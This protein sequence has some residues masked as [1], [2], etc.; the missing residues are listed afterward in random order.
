MSE[1][2]ELKPRVEKLE[3]M[4]NQTSKAIIEMEVDFKHLSRSVEKIEQTM[5]K[6]VQLM[7]KQ[8][9]NQ[10]AIK[11]AHHRIDALEANF[12]KC[13]SDKV[14]KVDFDKLD[15][16]IGNLTLKE[17]KGEWLTALGS[18]AVQIVLGIILAGVLALVMTKK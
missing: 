7:A 14:K 5:E 18:K 6:A 17:A 1:D 9:A 11:S 3:D 2:S 16:K 10:S 15:E 13:H 4:Y 8:D 12:S